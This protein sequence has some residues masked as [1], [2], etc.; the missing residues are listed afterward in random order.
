[1]TNQHTNQQTNQQQPSQCRE[2]HKVQKLIKR[3]DTLQTKA[4]REAKQGNPKN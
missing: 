1:M 2:D 3:I 4:I